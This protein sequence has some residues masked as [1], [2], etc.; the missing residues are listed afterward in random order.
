[1]SKRV[2][3]AR[4]LCLLAMLVGSGALAQGISVI[5]GTV[6]DAATKRAARGRR[7]HRHLTGAA[8]RA[9]GRHRQVRPVPH[10]ARC[11][12]ARTPC[13]WRRIATSP[14]RAAT[15]PLR[16]D[17]TIR[18]NVELLPEALRDEEIVVVGKPPTVDV[19][20]S[21]TGVS[22]GRRL[23][24]Q[25]RPH[26]PGRQGR[27]RR[28]RSSR[29]RSSPRAPRRTATACRSAAR[30][31]AGE[32]VRRRRPVGE[33]PGVRHRSG[34]PLSVEFVK[35]VERHHRRLPARVR[36]LHRRRAQRRHQVRLQR[37]PRLGVRQHR[38]PARSRGSARSRQREGSVDRGQEPAGTWATSAPSSAARSSRTSSGSTPAWRRPSPARGSSAAQRLRLCDARTRRR[39]QSVGATRVVRHELVPARPPR[40]RQATYFA[41][42]QQRPVH[43][44]ADLPHQPGPQPLAVRLR[45]AAPAPAATASLVQRR[46]RPARWRSACLHRHRPG[47]YGRIAT[48]RRDTRDVALK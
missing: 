38:R 1:M 27:A 4:G 19:G 32:P 15:S 47:T 5:T 48:Q 37:V 17:A 40:H 36:P 45:H 24:P 11:R 39:L 21:T 31:L 2:Q 8:G 30:T 43:R 29:W 25:H 35:E 28:A 41:D 3:L 33:R 34:T 42:E 6:T 18:V 7:R 46:R 26:P 10:P 20:S 23:H 12:P 44:Q 16:I 9:D 13:T 14:T 22:V